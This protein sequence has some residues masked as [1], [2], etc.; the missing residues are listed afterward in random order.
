MKAKQKNVTRAKYVDHA[1]KKRKFAG[2]GEIM[3]IKDSSY[4]PRGPCSR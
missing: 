4:L 2:L 1:V 3:I